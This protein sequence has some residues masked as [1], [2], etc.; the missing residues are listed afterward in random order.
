MFY[1]HYKLFSLYE[2]I[3]NTLDKTLIKIYLTIFD[4][5]FNLLEY[6]DMIVFNNVEY[7]IEED[8]I[9]FEIIKLI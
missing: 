5:C 6:C 7:F 4:K 9:K 8:D 2:K 3:L 1:I